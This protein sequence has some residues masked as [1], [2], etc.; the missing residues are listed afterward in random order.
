VNKCFGIS[1]K[2]DSSGT[3]SDERPGLFLM[4]DAISSQRRTGSYILIRWR[5]FLIK[6]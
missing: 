4:E 1:D 3:L 6:N 5:R 2:I